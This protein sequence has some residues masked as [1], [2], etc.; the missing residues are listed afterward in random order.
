MAD[1]LGVQMDQRAADL[2]PDI[3][4]V[5]LAVRPALADAV[6]DLS[7]AGKLENEDPLQLLLPGVDEADDVLVPSHRAEDRHLFLC[8]FDHGARLVH[9]LHGIRL[10]A[11]CL[12]AVAELDDRE[13]AGAEL[14]VYRILAGPDLVVVVHALL[15]LFPTVLQRDLQ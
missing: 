8:R 14:L 4:S 9:K 2:P 5:R 15:I 11:T 7:A 10:A 12:V 6:E 3:C 1:A 13:C